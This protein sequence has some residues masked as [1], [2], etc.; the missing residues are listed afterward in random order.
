MN[1]DMSV[2]RSAR[3]PTVVRYIR[4]KRKHRDDDLGAA[5]AAAVVSSESRRDCSDGTSEAPQRDVGAYQAS[6]L[7]L[8]EFDEANIWGRLVVQLYFGFFAVQFTVNGVAISWLFT[9]AGEKWPPYTSLVYLL[10]V[11]W[12]L[13]G[14]IGTVLVLKGLAEG[15]RRM[16]RVME[17]VFETNYADQ[18]SSDRPRSAMPYRAISIVFSFCVATL[19]L[20]LLFWIVM[21]FVGH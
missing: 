4:V 9:H 12:N 17:E 16:K 15:D 6:T 11:G 8:K 1:F 2:K 19:L 20:S 5:I 7:L 13:M 3:N 18:N 14:T 10:F 21:L